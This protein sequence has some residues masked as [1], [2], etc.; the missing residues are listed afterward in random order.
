[1][2]GQ[3]VSRGLRRQVEKGGS[4]VILCA[5]LALV[6]RSAHSLSSRRSLQW[7]V[8]MPR[9]MKVL[10]MQCRELKESKKSKQTDSPQR[11]R[12]R[13]GKVSNALRCDEKEWQSI[14]SLNEL[15][16]RVEWRREETRRAW[17]YANASVELTH[18]SEV[19][20]RKSGTK[21][22]C[23]VYCRNFTC[24]L[25]NIDQ[26]LFQM[27]TALFPFD[28]VRGHSFKRVKLANNICNQGI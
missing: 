25:S 27:V 7:S 6:V 10:L 16:V 14:T 8:P 4:V 28:A 15:L 24:S 19:S 17:E 11:R 26:Q 9:Q 12:G 13:W 20:R 5:A 23:T 2:V 22:G 18:P 21:K 3:R 1:M